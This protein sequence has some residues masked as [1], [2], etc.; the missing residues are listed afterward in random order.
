MKVL[1][2]WATGA[3]PCKGYWLICDYPAD[4]FFGFFAYWENH[5]WYVT[6]TAPH[7]MMQQVWNWRGLAFNPESVYEWPLYGK[8]DTV[9]LIEEFTL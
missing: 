5:Q 1:T 3:P 9:L 4:N 8:A 2:D 6:K 7:P